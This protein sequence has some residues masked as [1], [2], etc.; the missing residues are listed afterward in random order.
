MY[1]EYA[2]GAGRLTFPD[3]E[4][5]ST[6]AAVMARLAEGQAF[7]RTDLAGL[8]DATLDDPMRTNWDELWSPTWENILDHDRPRR[9]PRRRDRLP[10]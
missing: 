1:H 9:S 6:V 4:P 7:L 8:S 10:T 3:L 5:P 2:F